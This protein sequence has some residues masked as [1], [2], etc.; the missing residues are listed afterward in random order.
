VKSSV[1]IVAYDPKWPALYAEERDRI[2]SVVGNKVAAIEH[3]GSTAVPGLGAKPV[4]DIMVAVRH[5]SAAKECIGLLESIGYEYVPQYES[6]IPERRFFRKGPGDVPNKHFHL[7]MV[8]YS[9]GFWERH[10]LFRDYLRIHPDV[11]QQYHE[12]KKNLAKKHVS[13]REAY[14]EAKTSF[15]ESVVAKARVTL[16]LNLRYIRLPAQVLEMHDELIYRSK[17]VIVGRSQITSSHSITFDG[18]SVLSAGFPMVYFELVGK[19]FNVIK[20]RNLQGK[21]TGYYCDIATPPKLLEDGSIETT[22]LFLDLWVS[23]DLR[24]RVLDD[25]ELDEALKKGWITKQLYQKAKKELKKLA[26]LV[27]QRKFPPLLVRQLEEGLRL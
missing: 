20:I 16:K 17:K 5:L 22:D 7:H 3:V 9:S 26:A 14:T 11:R 6:T 15:I 18:E 8:E 1:K 4:V 12:L 23:P 13:N 2:L 10:L 27:E 25:K 24:Y 21:H 19:W